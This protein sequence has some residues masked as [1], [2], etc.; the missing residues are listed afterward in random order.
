M[1]YPRFAEQARAAGE[2]IVAERFEEMA[3]DEQEHEKTLEQALERLEV[4]V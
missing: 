1:T 2:L 3:E 4:P